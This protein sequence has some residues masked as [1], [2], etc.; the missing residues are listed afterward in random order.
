MSLKLRHLTLHDGTKRQTSHS[1]FLTY[2]ENDVLW[3]SSKRKLASLKRTPYNKKSNFNKIAASYVT[4]ERI[5]STCRS[6]KCGR[7]YNIGEFIRNLLPE[8][9]SR[10]NDI[11]ICNALVTIR[12]RKLCYQE[13]AVS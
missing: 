9:S 1:I 11:A 3:R 6:Y 7:F 2:S 10:S 5:S 12:S 4:C 8:L 13:K